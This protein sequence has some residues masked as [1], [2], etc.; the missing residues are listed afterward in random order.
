LNP[1]L[2]IDCHSLNFTKTEDICLKS[3]TLEWGFQNACIRRKL[4]LGKDI[5][6]ELIFQITLSLFQNLYHLYLTEKPFPFDLFKNT[7]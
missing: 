4:S 1:N 2:H 5:R 6:S 7:L 3:T